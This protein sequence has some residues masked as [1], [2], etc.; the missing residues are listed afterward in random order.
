MKRLDNLSVR[1]K[2]LIILLGTVSLALVLAW[3]SFTAEQLYTSHNRAISQLSALA[4]MAGQNSKASLAFDD[5]ATAV[6]TLRS[7][8]AHPGFVGACLYTST[9]VS[10][11][12]YQATHQHVLPRSSLKVGDY[13]DSG[14]NALVV[15]R[16]ISMGKEP[17][18]FICLVS[19]YRNVRKEWLRN[20]LL[21][22]WTLLASSGIAILVSLR[23]Q[24]V[25]INPVLDLARV[26]R[27]VSANKN[28][29]I[30]VPKHSQDEIGELIGAFNGMLE[31]IAS[32]TTE[33]LAMNQQ[34]VSAK[35]RAEEAARLKSEFLA[36]MSHEIRTPINGIMG[37]TSLAL[38]T[39]LN[40]EQRE[41][42]EIV[43]SSAD[44]LL[45]IVNDVLDFSKIEA[46]Q[47]SIHPESFDLREEIVALMKTVRYQADQKRLSLSLDVPPEIPARIVTD[48]LRLRQVLLNL[49]QNGLKFTQQGEVS[50]SVRNVPGA[51]RFNVSDT[52][53]GIPLD[54]QQAIF[55]AFVQADG[56][57][58]RQYGGTGL[59]LSIS[60]RLVS[61]LGGEIGVISEPGR[62]STFWFTVGVVDESLPTGV[63]ATESSVLA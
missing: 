4:E 47:L 11:A 62:G 22:L 43:S 39:D 60:A 26:A 23:F 5:R 53:I 46:G 58:T 36:N 30:R 7:L 8:S 42:L 17:I 20:A 9:G 18:G 44:S 57:H 35:D 55:H 56:S 19:D 59:G 41:F 45:T 16:S 29:W 50:L 34:L 63:S 32:N 12:C 24:R 2:M 40:D 21:A 49:I 6:E 51:L 52:G 10:F 25:I 38:D 54:R 13:T 37:M 27:E 48:P 14:S 28:Y 1:L 3:I 61:M 31:Q 15:V 33:L